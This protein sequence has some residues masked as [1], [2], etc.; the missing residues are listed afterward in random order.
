MMV[1]DTKPVIITNE[2]Y[3]RIFGEGNLLGL[4]DAIAWTLAATIGGVLLLHY[5]IFGPPDLCGRRQSDRRA[6][7]GASRSSA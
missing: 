1:T 5:N 7:F 3:F 6:L 2:R 4:P